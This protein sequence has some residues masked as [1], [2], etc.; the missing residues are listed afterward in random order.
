MVKKNYKLILRLFL[1]D[2]PRHGVR[3]L[4]VKSHDFKNS[5]S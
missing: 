5:T 2:I 1:D 3:G 4:E